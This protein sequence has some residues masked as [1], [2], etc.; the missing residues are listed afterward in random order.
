MVWKNGTIHE[1]QLLTELTSL[2]DQYELAKY[3]SS[4]VTLM[5]SAWALTRPP[6]GM[7]L[8]NKSLKM[9]SNL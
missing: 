1:L 4:T 7:R 5:V 6:V 9:V 3:D 8:S 2:K